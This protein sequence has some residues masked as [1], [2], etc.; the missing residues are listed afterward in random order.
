M[1]AANV[2]AAATITVSADTGNVTLPVTIGVCE[3]DLTSGTCLSATASSVITQIDSGETPAFGIF[4][5]GTGTVPFDRGGNR[6][7]VRFTDEGGI[8]RGS[9]RVAVQTQ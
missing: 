3:T 6:V 4:V 5:T 8:V 9:T 2:G 1:A 7:F